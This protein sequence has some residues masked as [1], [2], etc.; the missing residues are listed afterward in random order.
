MPRGCLRPRVWETG[1]WEYAFDHFPQLLPSARGYAL[2]ALLLGLSTLAPG[3]APPPA[4]LCFL[5]LR[6]TWAPAGDFSCMLCSRG[7]QVLRS[8]E[9]PSPPPL[10]QLGFWEE[11]GRRTRM[12]GPVSAPAAGVIRREGKKHVG[13]NHGVRR[14]CGKRRV[15][16]GSAQP[17]RPGASFLCE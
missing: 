1:P 6:S 11:N 4:P 5:P 9:S 8:E 3:E 12:L 14:A 17:T 10:P 2:L 15:G 7:I 13:L 16:R